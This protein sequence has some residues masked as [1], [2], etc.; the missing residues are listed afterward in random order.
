VTYARRGPGTA[1]S[2]D[3]WALPLFGDHKPF[4]LTQGPSEDMN[5]V[6]APDN[7]WFAYQAY[8]GGQNQIYVRAFP[9]TGGTFQVS[10]NGGSWPVWRRDGKELFFISP[11]S[12]MMAVSIDT[13]G[14]FLAGTPTPLFTVATPSST[15]TGG[16]HYAVTKDGQ[17]FLVNVVQ[18]QAAII[19]LTVAVNW[20]SAVQR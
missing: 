7:R 11:E 20:L 19:P 10:K 9:P 8:E 4:P 5:A 1:A 2:L 18:Q 16:R 17:R 15:G 6:I 13:S 12:R 14:Q 3:I